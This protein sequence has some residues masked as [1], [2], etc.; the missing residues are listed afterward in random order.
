MLIKPFNLHIYNYMLKKL[1]YNNKYV[2]YFNELGRKT[3]I[4]K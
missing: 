2:N 4:F 1:Y 3:P